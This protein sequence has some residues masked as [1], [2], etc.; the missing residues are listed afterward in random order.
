MTRRARRP[1]CPFF[2]FCAIL[3]C[4]GGLFMAAEYS[5]IWSIGLL[6]CQWLTKAESFCL[7]VALV[8]KIDRGSDGVGTGHFDGS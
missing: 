8:G 7:Y 1:H 2:I 3:R 5:A 6:H 4:D